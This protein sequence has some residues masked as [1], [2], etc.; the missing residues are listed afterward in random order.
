VI[1]CVF[2][3]TSTQKPILSGVSLPGVF[4]FKHKTKIVGLYSGGA[5]YSCGI[6]HPTGTCMMRSHHDDESEFCPVCRY[7][8]V[9][10][11]DPYHHEEI[12]RDYAD[13]YPFR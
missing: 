1:P 12:D 3:D 10:L 6:F 2:D 5:R 13:I 11:I 4:C 8:L 9:D 7:I